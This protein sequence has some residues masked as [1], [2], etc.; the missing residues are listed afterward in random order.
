MVLLSTIGLA[1][2]YALAVYRPAEALNRFYYWDKAI[3]ALSYHNIWVGLGPGGL[4]ARH[5]IDEP[6]NLP[7]Q[8]SYFHLHAHNLIVQV[9]A[10]LG[11]VGLA[12]LIL[13]AV[14]IL[15][16]KIHGRWQIA[17]LAAL[18]VHSLVDLPLYYPGPWL[19]FM[20]IAGSMRQV[21]QLRV[22]SLQPARRSIGDVQRLSGKS[23]PFVSSRFDKSHR[24]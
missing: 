18:V 4:A 3:Q 6:T 9:T 8:P 1:F 13:A 17:I 15:R 2:L 14:W 10:E 22:R 24:L 12:A 11:L 21:V 7:T 23:L 20:F 5:A 16:A 19:V